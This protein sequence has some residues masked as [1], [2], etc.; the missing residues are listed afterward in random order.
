MI[1]LFLQV[2]L[3]SSRSNAGRD[4]SDM[5]L[6]VFKMPESGEKWV[7]GGRGEVKGKEGRFKDAA[8]LFL[9]Q[10]ICWAAYF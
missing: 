2:L 3:R 6:A 1:K 9:S 4:I 7:G 5:Q 8:V 10:A